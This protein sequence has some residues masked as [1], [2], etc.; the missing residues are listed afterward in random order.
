M[1]Y[2]AYTTFKQMERY[3]IYIVFGLHVYTVIFLLN[4][5]IIKNFFGKYPEHIHHLQF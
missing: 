1:I 2:D 5:K 4:N 3:N